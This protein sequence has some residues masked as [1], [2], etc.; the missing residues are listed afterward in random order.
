M[1]IVQNYDNILIYHRH[2]AI[3]L[4]EERV[5]KPMIHIGCTQ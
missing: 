5:M 1:D 2:K 3:Y 4:I